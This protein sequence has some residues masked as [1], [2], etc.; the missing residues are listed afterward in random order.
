MKIESDEF[1]GLF[2]LG[3][4]FALLGGIFIGYQL[5]HMD[6]YNEGYDEASSNII[7]SGSQDFLWGSPR[8]FNYDGKDY[9]IWMT[10]R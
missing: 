9:I 5:G 3:C 10:A 4:G 2:I 8:K 7:C 1:L 6:G